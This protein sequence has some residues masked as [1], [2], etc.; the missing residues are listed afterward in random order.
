MPLASQSLPTSTEAEA[1]GATN[2]ARERAVPTSATTRSNRISFLPQLDDGRP[3]VRRLRRRRGAPQQ[4]VER[5]SE[6]ADRRVERFLAA[7]GAGAQQGTLDRGN[8]KAGEGLGVP[9]ADTFITQRGRDRPFPALEGSGRDGGELGVFGPG[10]GDGGDGAAD[11]LRVVGDTAAE[12]VAEEGER[13]LQPALVDRAFDQVADR[14]AFEFG[15]LAGELDL[16]AGEVV[17]DRA[18]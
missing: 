14:R 13:L 11:P 18:A 1:A 10:K 5:M 3:K 17:V 8:D 7:G 12:D 16:A 9:G 6:A 4:P 2:S 15:G